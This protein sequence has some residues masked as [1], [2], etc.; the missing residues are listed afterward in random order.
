MP[1]ISV[2]L[3][4]NGSSIKREI[5]KNPR[6]AIQPGN[7]IPSLRLVTEIIIA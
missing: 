4:I 6:M 3:I 7:E 5:P 2:I 1:R